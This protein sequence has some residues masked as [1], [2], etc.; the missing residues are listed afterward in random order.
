MQSVERH[1]S[2][3]DGAEEEFDPARQAQF[4]L[5]SERLHRG[6]ATE[7]LVD[8]L[9]N[10]GPELADVVRLP[11]SDDDRR[12][13]ASIL[14]REDEELTP[15]SLERAVRALRK[16]ALNRR[17]KQL[18]RALDGATHISD[19]QQLLALAEERLKVKRA[20]MDPAL[21]EEL[22]KEDSAASG[23]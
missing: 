14:M 2:A 8:A 6:L 18:E 15:E 20:L 12:L 21:A 23:I 9:L 22:G 19:R 11:L 5:K 1:T 10:A 13:L 3:R 4:V 16:K 7:S 17:L